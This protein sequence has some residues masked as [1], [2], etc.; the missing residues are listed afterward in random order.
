MAEGKK[1]FTAYCDWNAT[2]QKLTDEEAGKL[3]KMVFAYVN[4]LNPEPPDRITE[5]LFEP[6]KA[7]LK[8]DLQKWID[9]SKTNSYNGSLGGRPKKANGLEEKQNKPNAFSEKRNNPEKAVSVTVRDSVTERESDKGKDIKSR[10]DDFRLKIVPHIS[11][12]FTR[13]DANDFYRYWTEMNEGGY[14]M[15]FEKEK[16]WN[17][18]GRIVTW[19]KNKK[20]AP[21][22]NF[23]PGRKSLD[24]CDRELLEGIGM[25]EQRLI[26]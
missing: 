25:N 3:M 6:I 20:V 10:M 23:A 13:E 21:K 19:I 8:R 2:I 12:K 7:T 5:L 26:D 11:E 24:D 22:N 18:S 1:S 4:D 15:R 17:T 14:K 9:K 16:T